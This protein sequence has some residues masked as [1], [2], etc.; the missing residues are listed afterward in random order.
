MVI[1]HSDMP[2]AM[3]LQ[4][5][6]AQP[7]TAQSLLPTPLRHSKTLDRDFDGRTTIISIFSLKTG[8]KIL[9]LHCGTLPPEARCRNFFSLIR[10][11]PNQQA[12]CA[13]TRPW[14]QAHCNPT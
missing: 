6:Q 14:L 13:F 4:S 10:A 8:G 12:L 1:Y 9:S 11:L 5:K 2:A 3:L 7:S